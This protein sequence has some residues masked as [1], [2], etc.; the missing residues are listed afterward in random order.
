MNSRGLASTAAVGPWPALRLDAN[1]AWGVEDAVETEDLHYAAA[2]RHA[3]REAYRVQY[4]LGFHDGY[5]DGYQA[6]Y[7]SPAERRIERT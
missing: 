2:Y 7:A 4:E 6:G 3:Y 5:L 1:G